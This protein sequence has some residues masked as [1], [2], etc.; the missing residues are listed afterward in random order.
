MNE[1]NRLS[2]AREE[3]EAWA[4]YYDLVH[5]GLPGE[6]EFYVTEGV[7]CGGEV[8]E[9]GVGTGRIAIPIAMSGGSVT[10]LDISPAMLTIC[11]EKLAAVS[12]VKGRVELIEGD[13][14]SFDLGHQFALVICPYR[15]F[16]HLLRYEDQADCLRCV[17]AHLAPGGRFIMNQWAA[18]PTAVVRAMEMTPKG[19]LMP[20][21]Q[22]SVDEDTVVD[23]FHAAR[24]DEHAQTITEEHLLRERIRAGEVLHEDRIGL[25]RAWTTPREMEALVRGC[26][27]VVEGVWGGFDGRPF[28]PESTEMIW[29]LREGCAGASVSTRNAC[30]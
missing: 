17:L 30:L 20:V 1:P 13:M 23:H 27:F 7:M 22:Y 16:M 19:G 9:L 10:G 5:S 28:G 29:C 12:P 26:G 2:R 14:R 21:E 4:P 24:Y 8:L 18:R 3:Y 6:A 15:S 25:V 11:R